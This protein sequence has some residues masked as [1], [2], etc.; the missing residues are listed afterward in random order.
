MADNFE[1]ETYR[2]NQYQN[3]TSDDV[4]SGQM[5]ALGA[6][7]VGIAITDI[8]ADGLGTI[9]IF[10]QFRYD[11][12]PTQAWAIGTQLYYDAANDRLTSTAGANNMAGMATSRKFVGAAGTDRADAR[13]AINLNVE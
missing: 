6:G 8:A 10:G 2:I 11:A 5:I 9:Q 12:D 1:V 4:V 13:V 3:E 7:G